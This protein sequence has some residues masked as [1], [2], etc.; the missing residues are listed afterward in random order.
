MNVNSTDAS[1]SGPPASAAMRAERWSDYGRPLCLGA[2]VLF[3]GAVVEGKF[4][5]A[6]RWNVGWEGGL[7]FGTVCALLL[8]IPQALVQWGVLFALK[9]FT[10]L[11]PRTR[12]WLVNLP[13]VGFVT[14]T[15]VGNALD[16]Q[17]KH[18]FEVLIQKPA[19]PSL[20]VIDASTQ[21]IDMAI[22]S[23]GESSS[24]CHRLTGHRL[25]TVSMRC[26]SRPSGNRRQTRS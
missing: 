10:R 16:W 23:C 3:L 19:P 26:R 5:F 21:M 15:L 22:R 7:M 1:E 18:I 12:A 9:R 6:S 25:P 14:W 20:Q 11:S 24:T 13:A 17:P 4:S 8:G 2:V